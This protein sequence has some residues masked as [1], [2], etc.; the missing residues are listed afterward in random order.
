MYRRGLTSAKFSEVVRAPVTTVRYHLRL[1]RMADPRLLEEHH[2][3]Q[4]PA[5]KVVQVGQANLAAVVAL[6]EAEQRLPSRNAADPKERALAAWLRRRRQDNNAGTLAAEY[7][8][9]LQAVPG[10]ERTRQAKDEAR[11]DARLSSLIEYRAAGNDWPRHKSPDTEDERLLGVWLQYQRTKLA[12][13][14][15]DAQTT[16]RLDKATPGWRQGRIKGR[17]KRLV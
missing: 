2:A 1:A 14:Q 9:D 4:K 8:A 13:G 5:R 10:W 6:F 3:A 7:R 15:L 16:K 17:K 12:A 11:L